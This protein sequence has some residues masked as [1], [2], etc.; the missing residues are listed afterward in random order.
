MCVTHKSHCHKRI[1][2]GRDVTSAW[3]I[4]RHTISDGRFNIFFPV[5]RLFKGRVRARPPLGIIIIIPWRRNGTHR[6]RI[7]YI[8]MHVYEK[9]EN[10]SGCRKCQCDRKIRQTTFAWGFFMFLFFCFSW[11]LRG[12]W[13]SSFL[14][15]RQ[16]W[17]FSLAHFCAV[18]LMGFGG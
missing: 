9:F 3:N 13:N 1:I 10:P 14:D 17:M 5:Q 2:N 16:D 15:R 6:D 18:K 7:V 8:Y 12:Y 11:K 4:M